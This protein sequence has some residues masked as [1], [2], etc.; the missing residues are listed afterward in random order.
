MFLT[1]TYTSAANRHVK[2]GPVDRLPI[3]KRTGPA[4][5]TVRGGILRYSTTSK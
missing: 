3:F 5:V 4:I 2:N 1:E